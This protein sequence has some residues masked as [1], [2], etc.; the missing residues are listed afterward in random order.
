MNIYRKNEFIDFLGYEPVEGDYDLLAPETVGECRVWVSADYYFLFVGSRCELKKFNG[1]ES[2]VVEDFTR[3]WQKYVIKRASASK[4]EEVRSEIRA[5][6]EA[7]FYTELLSARE[8]CD[9]N[10]YSMHLVNAE[11]WLEVLL[12]QEEARFSE[13]L[14]N[15]N[16]SSED[17]E[18][19]EKWA[20]DKRAEM[21]YKVQ[22]VIAG[23]LENDVEQSCNEKGE[24]VYNFTPSQLEVYEALV[25][26]KKT[27]DFAYRYQLYRIEAK[28]QEKEL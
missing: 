8:S 9:G 25:E 2:F 20:Q 7:N 15:M 14:N 6:N 3:K 10:D 11:E 12:E 27:I 28:Q 26:M 19:L 16:A 13:K 22:C 1:E 4:R 5:E 24:E 18:K 21:N 17:T 23:M